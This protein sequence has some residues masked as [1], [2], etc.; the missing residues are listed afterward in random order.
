MMYC[1]CVYEFTDVVWVFV[2][3]LIVLSK[4]DITVEDNGYL[5][6]NMARLFEQRTAGH[7]ITCHSRILRKLFV[8]LTTLFILI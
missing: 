3:K 5:S 2:L 8:W 7:E 4:K 6:L 1:G